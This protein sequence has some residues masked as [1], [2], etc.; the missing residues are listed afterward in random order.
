MGITANKKK[1]IL[2]IKRNSNFVV[3][4]PNSLT[5]KMLSI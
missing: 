2:K 3:T 1:I 5:K 4:T